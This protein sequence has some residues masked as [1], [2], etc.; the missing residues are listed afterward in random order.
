LYVRPLIY[1]IFLG[2][3]VRVTLNRGCFSL[4]HSFDGSAY[5]AYGQGLVT[6]RRTHQWFSFFTA[7]YG[8]G[9]DRDEIPHLPHSSDLIGVVV[10]KV[11]G[12][13]S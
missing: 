11:V 1:L 3:V 5:L 13:D 4:F 12:L 10:S 2:L 9:E 8:P 6:V 7:F